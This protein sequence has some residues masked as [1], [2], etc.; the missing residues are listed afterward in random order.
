LPKM[1]KAEAKRKCME[2]NNKLSKIWT[3]QFNQG[4]LLTRSMKHKLEDAM[5][6]ILTIQ[7]HLTK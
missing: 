1:S 5:D 2:A 3:A 7:E 6:K 4:N